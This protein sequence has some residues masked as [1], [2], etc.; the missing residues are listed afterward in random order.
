[1]AGTILD[2]FH[3]T[4][5]NITESTLFEELYC[6]LIL[7]SSELE[8][9]LLQFSEAVRGWLIFFWSGL[10]ASQLGDWVEEGGL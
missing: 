4:F 2:R 3:L 6:Q 9:I 5:Q 1:M 10:V 7:P 8:K